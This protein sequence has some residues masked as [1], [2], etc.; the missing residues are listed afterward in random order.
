LSTL[1][2]D[3]QP[4]FLVVGN[5][6]PGKNLSVVAQ[7]I[8]RI[9]NVGFRTV[10]VGRNDPAVFA[11][12]AES[13]RFLMAGRIS[14][15]ALKSLYSRALALIFPSLYE[16]F[17]IPLLEAMAYDCPVIAS[18]IPST[19][20]VAGS[21]PTYFDPTN[22]DQL[23]AIMSDYLNVQPRYSISRQAVATR[24]AKYSWTASASSVLNA[25]G[26]F[27]GAGSNV[28]DP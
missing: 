15:G 1:F 28:G 26:S 27:E 11:H 5:L 9:K 7:A 3:D 8:E 6:A 24:F 12:V 10:V 25:V 22:A 2:S 21:I 16:G 20:E 18:D 4:Y 14:D 17:G 23:A 13:D 19:R